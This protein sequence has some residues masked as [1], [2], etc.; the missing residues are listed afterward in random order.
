[1]SDLV[2]WIVV[3]LLFVV[4]LAGTVLPFVPGTPLIVVGALIYAVA[5]GWTPIGIGRLVI[6]GALAALGF[7]LQH[8]SSALG[9]RRAGG[10]RWAV[11]GAIAG[12]VVGLFLGVAGLLLGPPLGAIA[13][14]MIRGADLPASV[15]TGIATFIGLLAGA[16]ANAAIGV[17]MVALFLWW[18]VRG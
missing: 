8:V 11:V 14:E 10:S 5:T 13:A 3:G 6:L 9:A 16:V 18:V 2:L 7:G 17:T 1:M 12:G 15:R 4:G